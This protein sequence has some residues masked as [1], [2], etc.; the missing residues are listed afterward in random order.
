MPNCIDNSDE[1][2]E[3]CG[4]AH[5]TKPHRPM[6]TPSPKPPTLIPSQTIPMVTPSPKPPVVISPHTPPTTS[7]SKGP[8]IQF[9]E[10]PTPTIDWCQEQSM[11]ACP[12]PNQ[13]FC[14]PCNNIQSCSALGL[15]LL[16]YFYIIYSVGITFLSCS[17]RG[18]MG[19]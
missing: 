13:H 16:H 10:R 1:S 18:R 4:P 9:P 2:E 7:Q 12:E 14:V 5:T 15:F 3:E 6:T 11:C 19:N 17:A 8:G